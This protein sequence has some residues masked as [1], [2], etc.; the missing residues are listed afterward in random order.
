MIRR[1][2]MPRDTNELASMVVKLATGQSVVPERP[3]PQRD[4]LAAELG[5]RGGL[6]G[7]NARKAKLS[8]RRRS[9][10]ARKAVLVRWAKAKPQKH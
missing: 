2:R 9:E 8:K 10:I 3:E 1:K 7:G 4:A 6:K 5:R